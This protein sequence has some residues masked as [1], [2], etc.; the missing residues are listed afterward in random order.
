MGKTKF[1]LI[2]ALLAFVTGHSQ[3]FFTGRILDEN[4]DP[5]AG[6]TVVIKGGT[7]GV[8]TDFDGQ[9]KIK[10][11]SSK[12]VLVISYMG[13]LPVEFDT[14]SKNEAIIILETDDTQLEEVV[15][16][17]LGISREEK[18]LGYAI[19]EIDGQELNEAREANF[20]NSLQGKVAGLNITS[21]GQV[22]SSARIVIRGENSLNFQ[23]NSPLY[24]VDG[25]PLGDTGTS[26]SSSVDYGNGSAAIN[27]ADIESVTIL[28]G[29]T[30]SALYGSR[31][32]DGVIVVTTKSG[33]NRKGLGIS[34]IS[35]F[36]AESILRLPK[37]QN[38]FGQGSNGNYEGSNFGASSSIYPDGIND[39]YDE[40][41]GPRLDVG[42]LERQF[43]SP[44]LGR[45]RGGDVFNPNRGEVIPTPWISQPDNIE[46]FFTTGKTSYN[47][48]SLN[49]GND[50]STLRLSYTNLDQKGV[51]PNNNLERN[52][53][54]LKAGYKVNEKLRADAVINYILTESSNRPETGY[55]RNSI[56]YFMTW[57][58]RNVDINS[59][60]DY[61]QTGLEGVN[62]FQYNYGENHNNPYFYQY[63][64]TNGQNKKRLFG[65]I[66]LT[67][68]FNGHLSLRG[69]AG[70]D[71]S[72][73]FRPMRMAVSTVGNELGR[74]YEENR[75]SEETN[76]DFL[77]TYD[78]KIGNDFQYTLSA[79]G[80]AL[81]NKYR[82]NSS[83]APQL[84]IPGLYT[85]ENSAVSV[86][87][88][89]FTSEIA[90]NSLYA[91]ANLAYRDQFYLDITTR[92]DWS[93]TLPSS[94]WSYFYPSA[95]LST[96]LHNIITMPDWISFAKM[97][98]GAAAV[99][100]DAS[101]YSLLTT[102]DFAAPWNGN[103]SLTGGDS[104]KNLFLKPE[105]TTSYEIGTDLRFLN[106]RLG[107]DVTYYNNKTRNQ[108]IPLQLAI[109]SGYTN[110]IIN[111]GEIEN[112][113]WEVMLN[114]I[115]IS[116]ENFQWRSAIN[117]STSK[118]KVI[119][120][121]EGVD[122]LVQQAPGEDAAI[123]ARVGGRM[124]EI[125]GPG[126]QRV[127]QGPMRGEIIIFED[128]RPKGTSED[129]YLGN[130]NSDWIGGFSNTFSY[131][132][133]SLSTLVDV[134]WGG[135][136]ISRFYNKA[137]GAGQLIE[138][139]KGRSARPVGQE[140]DD[141]Y[142]IEGV[143]I[144][145]EI[146]VPNSTST[147]GTYSEGVYGTDARYFHK[148]IDHISEAQLFDATYAKLREV[149]LGYS[150]PSSM[151]N[152]NIQNFRISIVGRNLFLWTPDSNQHFDPEVATA[153]TGSGLVPGFENMSLPSTRSLGINLE[154]KF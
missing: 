11:P 149:K 76:M 41:W 139:V 61:W 56:M 34:F 12:S 150:L 93:S 7:N 116:T 64:N 100:D 140:Y 77:L 133:L 18:S 142:Y 71:Y 22:G 121:A 98:L 107:I 80:N 153:T 97:R 57:M 48:L 129:I 84:T 143:A 39:G 89:S 90:V 23:D 27:P 92:N 69:R 82:Y 75:N 105:E 103:I 118:G 17:A 63:E 109:S 9:F 115:P 128:G 110:R 43:S 81:R 95:S 10:L 104:L 131:K 127:E 51:I 137:V 136:F 145:D 130:L 138:T 124:G 31:A 102:F 6:S 87:A 78:N 3:N 148:A 2:V 119:A 88:R 13:Y 122:K 38:E 108:I 146:Y 144:V 52:T 91:F 29:P 32:A 65:N 14:T 33:E 26:N 114:G 151:F 59:L 147:D 67:Y 135:K 106:S 30:A 16:T 83:L 66:A 96:L 40:S 126:Y 15:I 60:K 99:G 28:K 53:F 58:T 141:P 62:Q 21:S 54:A 86:V 154:V 5:L 113:G 101:A 44:T 74:Y 70:T 1:V 19:Q 123:I 72:D 24:I 85:I 111:A 112:S 120:L 55:G 152:D 117:F 125:W 73:D 68:D 36:S 50:K 79:G 47:N 132:N 46:D 42:T 49:A 134:H 35:G 25:V 94:N 20:V 45:M 37:F 4:N 8:I